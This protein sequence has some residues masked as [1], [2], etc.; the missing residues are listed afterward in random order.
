MVKKV[1]T[2]RKTQRPYIKLKEARGG[3]VGTSF[4]KSKGHGLQL[5]SRYR[6]YLLR[7]L[8]AFAKRILSIHRAMFIHAPVCLH[9]LVLPTTGRFSL[10]FLLD[11]SH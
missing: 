1:Y 6:L 3:V 5:E 7:L 4:P 10:N 9:G 11:I 2:G 8:E